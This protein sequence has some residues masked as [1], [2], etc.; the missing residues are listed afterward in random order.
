[1][2]MITLGVATILFSLYDYKYPNS[3]FSQFFKRISYGNK[4]V[5]SSKTGNIIG[6]STGVIFISIGLIATFL[7]RI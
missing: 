6:M 5:E 3:R 1:M 7:S 2:I 4:D